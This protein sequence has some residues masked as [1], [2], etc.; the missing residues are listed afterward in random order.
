LAEK[1]AEEQRLK[2]EETARSLAIPG[3]IAPND[4]R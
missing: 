1:E 2:K 3:M 4:P